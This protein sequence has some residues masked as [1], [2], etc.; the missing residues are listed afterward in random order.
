MYSGKDIMSSYMNMCTSVV[1]ALY[2]A[3]RYEV[4]FQ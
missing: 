3:S 1:R 4:V 2:M